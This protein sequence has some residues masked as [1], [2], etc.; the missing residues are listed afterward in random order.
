LHDRGAEF[1]QPIGVSS[2][3]GQVEFSEKKGLNNTSAVYGILEM[4]K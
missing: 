1:G 4:V 3:Y 2:C